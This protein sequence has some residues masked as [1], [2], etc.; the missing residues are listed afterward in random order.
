M[1]KA[2]VYDTITNPLIVISFNQPTMAD[3]GMTYQPIKV[4]ARLEARTTEGAVRN[5]TSTLNVGA[6]VQ[7]PLTNSQIYTTLKAINTPLANLLKTAYTEAISI[8]ISV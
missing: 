4:E 8:D 1:S 3:A 5:V 2:T 6:V 7:T